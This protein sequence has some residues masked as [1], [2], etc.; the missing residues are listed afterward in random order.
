[1]NLSPNACRMNLITRGVP[2][3]HLV[4]RRFRAGEAVLRGVKLNEPC[5]HLEDVVGKRVISVLV[6]RCGLHAEILNG[7]V[8]RQGDPV[9][10]L[11]PDD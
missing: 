1:M 2:L 4:G 11:D 7:G 10:E 3:S 6:H 8:I 5:R 9:V